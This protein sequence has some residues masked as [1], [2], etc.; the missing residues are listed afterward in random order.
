MGQGKCASCHM[1]PTYSEP[2]FNMHTPQEICTDSFQADRSPDGL[3]RTTPLRGAWSHP[4]GG[5]YH[6][7]RFPDLLA[8]V[9]HYDQ[10]FD[11]GLS[12]SQKSDLVQFLNSR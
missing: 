1:P 8:V 3:Y 7:G 10:C 9:D 11:L 12:A 2:G 4:K 6:D 5:Y